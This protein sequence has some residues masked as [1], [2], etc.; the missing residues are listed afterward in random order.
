[1][2]CGKNSWDALHHIITPTDFD[3]YISGTHNRSMLNSSPICN[4][5]CHI[6]RDGWLKKQVP[7]LLAKTKHALLEWQDYELKENDEIF[8]DKYSH[9]Y[10]ELPRAWQI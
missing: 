2:V 5:P 3:F 9:L 7:T 4:Y 10:G 6:G 8:I 1:M